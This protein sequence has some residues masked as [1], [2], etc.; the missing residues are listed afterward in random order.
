MPLTLEI[1]AIPMSL[2]LLVAIEKDNYV[3][4]LKTL[5]NRNFTGH[6]INQTRLAICILS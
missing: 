2:F 4:H 1:K 6:E 3:L 5:Q